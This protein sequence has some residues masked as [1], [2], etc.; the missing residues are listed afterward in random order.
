MC[1]AKHTFKGL[2]RKMQHIIMGVEV[3]FY[4]LSTTMSG[5]LPYYFVRVFCVG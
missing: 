5:D 1:P 3:Q 2:R 4:E